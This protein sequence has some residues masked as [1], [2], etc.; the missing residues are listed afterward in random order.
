MGGTVYLGGR[1]ESKGSALES[2]SARVPPPPRRLGWPLTVGTMAGDSNGNSESTFLFLGLNRFFF[3]GGGKVMGG[4]EVLVFWG[5]VINCFVQRV[6]L[7]DVH[8]RGLTTEINRAWLSLGTL[9][10]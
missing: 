2:F 1:L 4:S 5:G 3:P 9:Y 6:A 7:C 10:R 8:R